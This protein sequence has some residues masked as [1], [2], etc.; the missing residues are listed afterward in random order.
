VSA[1]CV[2][3]LAVA[4]LALLPW[5]VFGAEWAL[6]PSWL[7]SDGDEVLGGALA[8]TWRSGRRLA[9]TVEASLHTGNAGGENLRELAVLAGPRLS[10]WP[11]RRL[12]PFLALKV[13]GVRARRQVEVF[14]L[15]VGASG[16]C[17]GGCPAEIGA[18]GEAGGGFDLGLTHRIA[19]RLPEAEY[20]V[21]RIAGGW[22]GGLRVSAGVVAHW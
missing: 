11:T 7:R 18:T 5:P 9:F 22:K 19:L 8:A 15:A 4:F 1:R 12:R 2:P 17:D 14:G 16:V 3:A 21:S 6:G 10:P 13:G 20:R